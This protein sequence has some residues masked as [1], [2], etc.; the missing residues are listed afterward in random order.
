MY[1]NFTEG[2]FLFLDKKFPKS[3]EFY[4]LESGLYPSITVFVEAMNTLIQERHNHSQNCVTVKVSRRTQKVDISLANEGSG[5]A[6]LNT[7]LGHISGSSV[8]ND[9][10]VMLRC[11]GPN[12]PEFAYDI[13]HIPSLMIYK[14]LIESIIFGQMKTLL[15]R[16]FF[17]FEAQGWRLYNNWTYMNFQTFS[18][19]QFRPL[20]KTLF[21]EHS[22]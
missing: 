5:L 10:G 22:H 8:G 12:K 2:K 11:L 7:D 15:L 16:C 9:F 6:F 4:Y 14:D 1:K 19:L 17:Y 13:V 21:S 3:S 20:L 18:H